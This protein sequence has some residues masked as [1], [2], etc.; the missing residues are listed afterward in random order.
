MTSEVIRIRRAMNRR[1]VW[2]VRPRIRSHSTRPDLRKTL[3]YSA[4]VETHWVDQIVELSLLK[5]E[6]FKST[7]EALFHCSAGGC[8]VA[9]LRHS[10]FLRGPPPADWIGPRGPAA[11]HV[12]PHAHARLRAPER[13][14][15]KS[16]GAQ[17]QFGVVAVRAAAHCK[18]YSSITECVVSEVES[19]FLGIRASRGI[20]ASFHVSHP[21]QTQEVSKMKAKMSLGDPAKTQNTFPDPK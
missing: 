13:R 20:A 7:E 11:D 19:I 8:Q 1:C 10:R 4:R 17:A 18:S 14:G 3:P 9:D 6:A 2:V 5:P 12:Q 15:Q 16:S 21:P